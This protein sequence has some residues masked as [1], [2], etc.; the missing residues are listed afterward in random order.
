L[1]KKELS[2]QVNVP[3]YKSKDITLLVIPGM[4]YQ[5]HETIDSTAKEIRGLAS[6]LGISS[7]I[8]KTQQSETI[9]FNGQI[10][11]NYLYAEKS[12]RIII[13]SASKGST[14]FLESIKICG[15][16]KSYKKIIGWIN[17]GGINKG[18][19]IVDSIQRNLF[20]Y[21]QARFYFFY[22][23]LNWN[24]L[25][26]ISYNPEYFSKIN[27][28]NNIKII[29]IVGVPV[30]TMITERARPYYQILSDLGPNEGMNLL[31]DS[32]LKNSITIPL[33]RNDHY[34][35]SPISSIRV[36][37]LLSYLVEITTHL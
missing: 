9:Q 23:G 21:L 18:T 10:I 36:L 12:S 27:I 8:I 3:N 31:G 22:Y 17:I 28:P 7:S 24:G 20:N 1:K 34:F 5:I 11:C 4:F 13:L 29:N 33:W 6:K 19:L 35:Q 25:L 32:Y 15:E 37:A 14:D 30:D 26:S 2:L 16:H